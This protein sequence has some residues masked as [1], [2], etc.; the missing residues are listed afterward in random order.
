MTPTVKNGLKVAGLGIAAC[1][2][3]CAPIL[4]APIAGLIAA[5]GAGLDL[6]GQVGL[7]VLVIAGAG[8]YAVLRR[9]KAAAEKAAASCN[10]VP[11]A[12]CNVGDACQLPAADA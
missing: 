2:A 10:C 3:C 8:A 6:A 9:R 1:A 4:I 11:D 5:G 12:G 7:G